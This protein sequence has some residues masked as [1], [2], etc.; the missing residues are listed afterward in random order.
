MNTPLLSPIA[1]LICM[2]AGTPKDLALRSIHSTAS[3]LTVQDIIL[4]RIDGGAVSDPAPF[5]AAAAPVPLRIISASSR[6]GLARCLNDLIVTV[7]ADNTWQLIARM[8]IDDVSMPRRMEIQRCFLN[9]NP[10]IDILGTACIEVSESGQY[11]QTKLMPLDHDAILRSLPRC[12]PINHPS[13]MVRRRVFASGIRY[14]ADVSYTEDYHLWIDAAS[15][16]FIFA[17]LSQ[18]LLKYTRDSQFFRRRGGVRQAVA[19]ARV[20]FRAIFVLRQAGIQNFFWVIAAFFM[21]L[22]PGLLQ[23]IIY[24]CFR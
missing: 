22:L 24:L 3:S 23:K 6:E 19:D 16:G 12:N 8:D 2:R 9:K 5:Y 18:P 13:V 20:R 4:L 1:T 11:I 15:K 7:L 10:E 17:N 14:R 21:R